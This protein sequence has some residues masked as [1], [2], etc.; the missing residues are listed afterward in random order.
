MRSSRGVRYKI[1]VHYS[2][3]FSGLPIGDKAGL[4]LTKAS[5]K[6]PLPHDNAGYF[7]TEYLFPIYNK[8]SWLDPKIQ[9]KLAI[10]DTIAIIDND[11][12]KLTE[13]PYGAI[14]LVA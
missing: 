1:T 10:N 13:S 8:K 12:H 5:F 14:M 7:Q 3:T 4:V 11:I 9:A 6:A 2:R